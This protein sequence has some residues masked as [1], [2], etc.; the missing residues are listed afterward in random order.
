M[1]AS[2]THLIHASWDRPEKPEDSSGAMTMPVGAL[3]DKIDELASTNASLGDLVI[4]ANK[5]LPQLQEDL[6]LSREQ[7][8]SLCIGMNHWMEKFHEMN[9]SKR[10]WIAAT[11]VLAIYAVLSGLEFGSSVV[12]KL[13]QD[14]IRQTAKPDALP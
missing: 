8:H 9:A 2:I 12:E 4:Q 11:I 13:K 10:K 14:S 5:V 7:A 3:L 6:N 1:E